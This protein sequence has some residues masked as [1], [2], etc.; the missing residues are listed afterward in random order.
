MLHCIVLIGF[1]YSSQF[2]RLPVLDW[3]TL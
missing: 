1:S 2:H 3:A